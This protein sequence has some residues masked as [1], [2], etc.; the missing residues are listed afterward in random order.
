VDV[1]DELAAKRKSVLDLTARFEGH[2]LTEALQPPP[3]A[4][5]E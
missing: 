4:R 2:R 5:K 1:A 3:G